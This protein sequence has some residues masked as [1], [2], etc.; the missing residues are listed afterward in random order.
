[1]AKTDNPMNDQWD[2]GLL[3]EADASDQL[4]PAQARFYL[5]QIASERARYEATQLQLNELRRDFRALLTREE[6]QRESE[7]QTWMDAHKIALRRAEQA[8]ELV[9]EMAAILEEIDSKPL[10]PRERKTYERL[11]YVLAK[12]AKYSLSKLTSDERMIQEYAGSIG[13]LVPT[14]KG[15]IAD[16]LE[17]AVLRFKSDQVEVA[18]KKGT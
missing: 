7:V 12:E 1:M 9:E 17:A 18:A 16:K 15:P 4:E 10:D 6:A 5:Q 13:A 2:A 14:G 11:I 8:E 3:K